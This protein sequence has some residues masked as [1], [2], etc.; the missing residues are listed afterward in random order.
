MRFLLRQIMEQEQYRV[1]EAESGEEGLT[2]FTTNQPDIV[3]LDGLLPTMDGLPFAPASRLCQ[4]ATACR[5]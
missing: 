2:A 4:G 1:V 5:S 3:L